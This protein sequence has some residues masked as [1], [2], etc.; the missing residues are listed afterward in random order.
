MKELTL[1]VNV[2]KALLDQH[3]TNYTTDKDN[4]RGTLTL[5]HEEQFIDET[6]R[7]VSEWDYFYFSKRS[8]YFFHHFT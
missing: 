3:K 6:S 2:A 4:L 5:T 7:W 1:R 8:K